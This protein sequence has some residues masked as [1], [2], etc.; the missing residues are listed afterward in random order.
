MFCCNLLHKI[1]ASKNYASVQWRKDSH[2][3]MRLELK[4][5][6]VGMLM[7]VGGIHN[8]SLHICLLCL[9]CGFVFFHVQCTAFPECGPS[10]FLSGEVCQ[11]IPSWPA[12]TRNSWHPESVTFPSAACTVVK[13][14]H[15]KHRAVT[16]DIYLQA[17]V[18]HCILPWLII[19]SQ[20]IPLWPGVVVR[21]SYPALS[22]GA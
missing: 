7:N 21:C 22:K 3:E 12:L 17:S 14:P 11:M 2:I 5:C 15:L 18:P 9:Q 8:V 6:G 20:E 19:V 1:K 4:T 16:P 10:D 13:V